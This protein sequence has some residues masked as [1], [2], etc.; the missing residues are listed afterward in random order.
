V[1]ESVDRDN[2]LA[3][4]FDW[5][6]GLQEQVYEGD[7]RDMLSHYLYPYRITLL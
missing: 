1:Y 3:L 4:G 6:L 5:A 2:L 7:Q